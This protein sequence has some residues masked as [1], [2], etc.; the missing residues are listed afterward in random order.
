MTKRFISVLITFFVAVSALAATPIADMGAAL[1]YC[2]SKELDKIEGIWEFP[3][4]Q[5]SVLIKRTNR[6]AN[7]YD[8]ILINTPDC[9]LLPG[10]T[11]GKLS[12]SADRNRFKLSLYMKRDYGMLASARVC[13][14]EFKDNYSALHVHP[15]K[16]NLSLGSLTGIG[17]LFLPKFWRLVRVSLDNPS[18]SLPRGLRRIYPTPSSNQKIS[19]L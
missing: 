5:T 3:E 11:I 12:A 6:N 16:L 7:D 9:R 15:M 18:S 19:Y 8:L 4:D 1:Q 10:E 2:D 13:T 17:Q 14:A